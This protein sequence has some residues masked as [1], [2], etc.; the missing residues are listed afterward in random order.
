ME[1]SDPFSTSDCTDSKDDLQPNQ[2]FVLNTFHQPV[3]AVLDNM[4]DDSTTDIT[5]T[6]FNFSR[7]VVNIY[8]HRGDPDTN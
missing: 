6:T 1:E 5:K 3:S 8:R 7:D 4:C 2:K